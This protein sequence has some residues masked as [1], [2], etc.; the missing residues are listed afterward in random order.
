MSDSAKDSLKKPL[1][2][3]W[4]RRDLRLGDHAAFAA[5]AHHGAPVTAV[6]VFD[7]DILKRFGNKQ[8]RR[9][10]FIAEALYELHQKISDKGGRLLVLHGK[11]EQLIPKL[12]KALN[13]GNLYASEDF[14]PDTRQRDDAVARELEKATAC[15]FVLDHLL[16]HPND[17]L[18]SDGTPYKVFTPYSKAWRKLAG[19]DKHFVGEMKTHALTFEPADAVGA[20]LRGTGIEPLPVGHGAGAL[21]KAIG[22]E[23]VDTGWPVTAARRSLNDFAAHHMR[24]YQT[25]RNYMAVDGT[26]RLSPYLRHGLISIREC[27]RTAMEAEAHGS[28]GASTWLGELIWRE[29]YAMILFHYPHTAT[30]EMQEQYRHIKW[31]YDQTHLEA[32]QQGKTGFPIVDAALRELLETGYMH[33]RARMIVASFMTKDLLLDWRAGEEHFAQYLMDYELSS[34]VGGWQWAASTGTDA[35]PYF[36]IFNPL[37][38]SQKFDPKGDYIRRYVPELKDLSDKDI[39]EPWKSAKPKNYPEP[40]VDHGEMR[41]KALA[42]YKKARNA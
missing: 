34:N 28:G 37:L 19:E 11:A 23:K 40:I 24:A 6:F 14:E 39:H 3:V 21:L 31:S 42:M 27:A 41:A 12:C 35:Q 9:F 26:S 36:R 2:L 1:S 7:S 5:A 25:E 4:L 38:Q 29:F 20:R 10:T 22:Y 8:D 15:H 18:K 33:N 32:F 30:Q 13:V 17:L 16:I